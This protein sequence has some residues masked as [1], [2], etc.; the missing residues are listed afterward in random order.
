MKISLQGQAKAPLYNSIELLIVQACDLYKTRIS[1]QNKWECVAWGVG[2]YQLFKIASG[3][4]YAP[5]L[6]SVHNSF[7]L[8]QGQ[9][10]DTPTTNSET[11]NEGQGS[12][13]NSTHLRMHS[14][15]A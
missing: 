6:H 2:L 5:L 9:Q 3:R 1:M 4:Q 11:A 14:L 7:L 15:P 13:N 8:E 12:S 10:L